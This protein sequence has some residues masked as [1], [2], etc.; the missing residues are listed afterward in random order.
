MTAFILRIQ[1]SN[2]EEEKKF[3]EGRKIISQTLLES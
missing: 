3:K 1:L 2:K